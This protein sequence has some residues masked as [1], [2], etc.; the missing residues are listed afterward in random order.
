ME[1]MQPETSNG[2][3]LIHSPGPSLRVESGSETVAVETRM[4]IVVRYHV[5]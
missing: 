1:G 3:S 4:L 5:H 2:I